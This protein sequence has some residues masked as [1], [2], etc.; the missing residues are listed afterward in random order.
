M[1]ALNAGAPGIA[2]SGSEWREWPAAMKRSYVWGVIDTWNNTPGISRP[3]NERLSNAT[4][5]VRLAT[6]LGREVTYD[7]LYAMVE[8]FLADNPG[9]LHADM[10][11][12]IWAAVDKACAAQRRT[13]P[14]DPR[15]RPTR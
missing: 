4:P 1:S 11:S 7:Q 12:I 9:Q 15:Y 5:Y 6:Q 2:M 13:S 14:V 3:V 8:K 10:A